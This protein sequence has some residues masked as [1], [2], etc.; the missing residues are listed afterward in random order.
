M[1]L[2]RV[3]RENNSFSHMKHTFCILLVLH[4]TRTL[5]QTNTTNFQG[6]VEFSDSLDKMS[7]HM[8][9]TLSL[10][11]RKNEP[12][13]FCLYPVTF[14]VV[15]LVNFYTNSY[16]IFCLLASNNLI[17]TFLGNKYSFTFLEEL[18]IVLFFFLEIHKW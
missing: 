12:W 1:C 18:L 7:K 9:L 16:D 11:P 8:A 14:K 6:S 5:R 3:P 2:Y 10:I 17:F 13:W 4:R 15:N